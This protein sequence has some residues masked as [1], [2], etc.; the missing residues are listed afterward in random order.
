MFIKAD[1][2]HVGRRTVFR[3]CF[4]DVH[5]GCGAD[6]RNRDSESAG[7]E[8][9]MI[10]DLLMREAILLA[11][12]GWVFGIG[13]ALMAR[14]NDRSHRSGFAQRNQCA[15]FLALGCADRSHRRACSVQFILV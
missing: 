11:L 7:S 14:T 5:G 3:W 13:M 4:F 8:A 1:Y 12:V 6:A 9:M 10:V 2:G 15:G